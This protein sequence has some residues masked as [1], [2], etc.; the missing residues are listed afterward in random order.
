M[1]GLQV[2]A[3]D[4]G[5]YLDYEARARHARLLRAVEKEEE[6][7]A[8]DAADDAADPSAGGPRIYELPPEVRAACRAPGRAGRCRCERRRPHLSPRAPALRRHT[9]PFPFPLPR[10]LFPSPAT[11]FMLALALAVSG[12]EPR[13]CAW[14][15]AAGGRAAGGGH[16]APAALL[17]RYPPLLKTRPDLA[18]RAAAEASGAGPRFRTVAAAAQIPGATRPGHGVALAGVEASGRRRRAGVTDG[19]GSGPPAPLQDAGRAPGPTARAWRAAAAWFVFN[20]PA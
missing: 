16:G 14:P 4:M 15:A 8:A 1:G 12:R 2:T 10:T 19:R 9:L 11:L 6:A 7:A 18:D 13:A 17:P 5:A 3:A 20:R